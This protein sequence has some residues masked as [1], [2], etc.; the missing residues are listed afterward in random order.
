VRAVVEVDEEEAF[1]EEWAAR[2]EQEQEQEQEQ[3]GEE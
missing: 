2:E 3:E 1:F